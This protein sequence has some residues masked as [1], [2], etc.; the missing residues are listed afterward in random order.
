MSAHPIVSVVIAAFNAEADIAVAVASALCQ[1]VSN[2]EVIVVAN[3]CTDGTAAIV[4]DMR[5]SDARLRLIEVFPNRGPGGARNVAYAAA[6]G[7]WIA[8]L[9]ADDRFQPRRLERLLAVAADRR[10]D[11]VA[12]N[13]GVVSYP[14]RIPLRL[15][16][17]NNALAASSPL[18]ADRFIDG[19]RIAGRR[20]TYGYLKPLLRRDALIRHHLRY[21]EALLVGEDYHFMLDCLL[22]G[23]R[24][25]LLDEAHYDYALRPGS[26]SRASNLD[27]LTRMLR[28]SAACMAWEGLPAAVRGAMAARHATLEKLVRN[29]SFAQAVRHGRWSEALRAMADAPVLLPLSLA[30]AARRAL[31]PVR[32][33][34]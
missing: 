32:D 22:A 27:D 19:N 12:D 29:V 26:L 30:Y 34:G 33:S 3:G 15:A 16:F 18:T 9:D 7:H 5:R 2:I 8:P 31:R 1:S 13:L 17:S 10:A 21:D 6:R 20:Y 25:H 23:L 28:Q 14:E 11:M 24:L 4:H